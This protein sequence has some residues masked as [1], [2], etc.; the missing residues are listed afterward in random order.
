MLII[1]PKNA[2]KK[3]NAFFAFGSTNLTKEV[4]IVK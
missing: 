3:C 4:G 2:F 1:N